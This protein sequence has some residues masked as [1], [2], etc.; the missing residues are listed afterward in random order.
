MLENFLPPK[1]IFY[2]YNKVLHLSI[3]NK[4]KRIICIFNGAYLAISIHSSP[5]AACI[6]TFTVIDLTLYYTFPSSSAVIGENIGIIMTLFKLLTLTIINLLIILS[7]RAFPA[8]ELTS[9]FL[10]FRST[11][12]FTR[13][14][15]FSIVILCLIVL[16]YFSVSLNLRNPLVPC[17]FYSLAGGEKIKKG[18]I[19]Y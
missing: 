12:I 15:K 3:L 9:G 7:S 14:N 16:S 18:L 17:I 4:N 8:V 6:N 10:V 13:I 11:T 5:Y 1:S 2:I 19:K